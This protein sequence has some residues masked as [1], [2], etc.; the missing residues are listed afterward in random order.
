MRLAV[1]RQTT[2]IERYS[3][4]NPYTGGVD[5]EP[6]FRFSTESSIYSATINHIPTAPTAPQLFSEC[7]T[8]NDRRK[9]SNAIQVLYLV[10]FIF[11]SLTESDAKLTDSNEKLLWM[12]GKWRSEFNGKVVWPTVPTMT[13]GEELVIAEAPMAKTTKAQFF[14]FR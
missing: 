14:N 5:D 1:K 12:V 10:I 4:D 7:R 9:Y 2:A 8:K 11:L 3:N 13:Y 6:V